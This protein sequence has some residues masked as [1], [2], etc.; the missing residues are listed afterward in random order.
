MLQE[1]LLPG[2]CAEVAEASLTAEV[3]TLAMCDD[4]D[5]VCSSAA[6]RTFCVVAVSS[7][8]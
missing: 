1:Q 7:A 8:Q 4:A 5:S 6:D 3:G 2:V